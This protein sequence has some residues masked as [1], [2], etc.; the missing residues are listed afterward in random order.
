M[1]IFCPTPEKTYQENPVQKA[2]NPYGI[3]SS[4]VK[5]TDPA[6]IKQA[7]MIANNIMK[8]GKE[9]TKHMGVY[10]NST[11]ELRT[12]CD[13]LLTKYGESHENKIKQLINIINYDVEF[14]CRLFDAT[15][16]SLNK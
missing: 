9:F 15:I 7:A 12:M 5:E 1:S 10:N 3:F 14:K 2:D 16:G 6:E 13:S 11:R 4:I 8:A